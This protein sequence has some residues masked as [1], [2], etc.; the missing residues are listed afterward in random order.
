M[1][2]LAFC[3]A[4]VS[5]AIDVKNASGEVLYTVRDLAPN[6]ISAVSREE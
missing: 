5:L 4:L 6:G 3:V 1:G 2:R